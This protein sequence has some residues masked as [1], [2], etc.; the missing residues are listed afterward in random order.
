MSQQSP[1]AKARPTNLSVPSVL[2][3]AQRHSPVVK[4][5]FAAIYCRRSAARKSFWIARISVD[6]ECGSVYDNPATIE[7]GSRWNRTNREPVRRAWSCPAKHTCK[8]NPV[9]RVEIASAAPDQVEGSRALL[10]ARTRMGEEAGA[11]NK[12]NV[13]CRA[14][15]GTAHPTEDDPDHAKQ[16]QF[17]TAGCAKQSQFV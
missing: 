14:D 15:V 7:L 10:L 17:Q 9:S 8:P 6:G 16:S 13:P 4:L 1:W 5:D 2:S 12:A 3:V 11:Q